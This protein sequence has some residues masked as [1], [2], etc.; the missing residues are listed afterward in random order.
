MASDV[1]ESPAQPHKASG[2]PRW[3][4]WTTAISALV[5]SV[6]S[7][8]I[9]VYNAGIESRLLKASSYP[10][11]VAGVSDGQVDAPNG[12][13][14]I[15]VELLNN[16]V[17]PADERSLKI[18]LGDRYVSSVN[19]LVAA[20]LGPA[21][22]GEA[23]RLLVPAYDNEPDRFIA[24]KDRGLVFRIDK[25]PQNASYWDRFDH[26][27]ITKRLAVEFCYCSVF[28]QCWTVTRSTR[29]RVKACV[30]DP[31][32]E[33]TAVPRDQLAGAD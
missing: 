2:L 17:G 16:G 32:L 4:E 10:Y 5:I 27:L 21:E 8:G 7:I 33:F 22:A 1:P 24:S 14:R 29:S 12:P 6:C 31:H 3:L 30:R 25:T 28:E 11:V 26:A 19:D 9:A 23:A 13:E 15:S 20:A 18:R